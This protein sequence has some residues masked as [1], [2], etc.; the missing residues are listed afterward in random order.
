[1]NNLGIAVV[2]SYSVEDELKNGSLKQIKTE[3]DEKTYSGI[4]V[5]HKNKWISPQ[6]QLALDL[7]A[8]SGSEDYCRD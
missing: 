4:Y 2:P 1:M 3:L 8:Q 5:Y 6:M 7:L